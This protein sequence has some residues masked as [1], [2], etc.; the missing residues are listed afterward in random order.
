MDYG[1]LLSRSFEITRKYRALWLFGI[2]VA[3]FG[4]GGGG[5][6]SG[7]FGFPGTPGADNNRGTGTFPTLPT[8]DQNLI[9]AIVAI[10][11]GIVIVWFI[12]GIFFR[13]VSRG[14]L[15]G[16]VQELEADQTAPTV[17]RGFRIGMDRF[18][19]LFG[20]ALLVNIPLAMVSVVLILVAALPLLATAFPLLTARPSRPS[21]EIIRTIIAG[22]IG[23]LLLFC[24][25]VLFAPPRATTGHI[26]ELSLPP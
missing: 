12:A 8:F 25:V 10:A 21:E 19:S 2:L 24:C 18:K 11:L 7:N 23:S 3:L 17:R 14:A 5:G 1:K 13:F 26:L 6:G 9:L 16:L 15:I 20:I 4:G 22:G